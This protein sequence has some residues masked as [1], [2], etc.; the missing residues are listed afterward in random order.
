MILCCSRNVSRGNHIYNVV[1]I[2][3]STWHKVQLQFNFSYVLSSFTAHLHFICR[4]WPNLTA[5]LRLYRYI[6]CPTRIGRWEVPRGYIFKLSH[7]HHSKELNCWLIR[8][9]VV[10]AEL[11]C[12]LNWDETLIVELNR[13]SSF[14]SWACWRFE[15]ELNPNTLSESETSHKSKKKLNQYISVQ[16][17]YSK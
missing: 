5:Y 13:E 1:L 2:K 15:F 12:E 3:S 11:S 14:V 6:A 16:Y 17:H 10:S 9:E 7:V 4:H 8:N